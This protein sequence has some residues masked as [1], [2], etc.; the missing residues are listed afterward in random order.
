MRV[1]SCVELCGPLKHCCEALDYPDQDKGE[2]W[3]KTLSEVAVQYGAEKS[4]SHWKMEYAAE[5]PE[6]AMLPDRTK[7]ILEG[8]GIRF[9]DS[10]KGCISMDQGRP[11]VNDCL[12]TIVPGSVLRLPRKGRQVDGWERLSFQGLWIP[13]E[14]ALRKEFQSSFA[15]DMGGNAFPAFYCLGAAISAIT[16]LGLAK[17]FTE[18]AAATTA[19][20]GASSKPMRRSGSSE[21]FESFG[22]S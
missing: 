12:P 17:H 8:L 20:P 19:A 15:A 21:L 3:R 6:F 11:G 22:E 5:F 2:K 14:S 7:N 4:L 16:G 1:S 9:P 18:Q 10:W 13:P